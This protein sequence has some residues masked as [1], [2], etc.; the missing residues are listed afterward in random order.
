MPSSLF[1]H[2]YSGTGKTLVAVHVLKGLGI[3]ISH[4]NCIE[5]YSSQV[6]FEAV[7]GQF[8]G[9]FGSS[10]VCTPLCCIVSL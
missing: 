8:C 3:H 1:L 7:L 9:E 4:V 2:G 10:G 6:L 5:V